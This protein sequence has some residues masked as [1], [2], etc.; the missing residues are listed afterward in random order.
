M[1]VTETAVEAMRAA[2][3]AF[4]TG[5]FEDANLL[6]LHAKRVTLMPKDMS[7]CLALRHDDMSNVM[8]RH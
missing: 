7:L 2:S 5:V 8:S 3:E 6:A 1:R 4:L